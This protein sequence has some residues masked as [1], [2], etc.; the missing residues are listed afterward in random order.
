MRLTLFI[1]ALLLP[2]TLT[3]GAESTAAQPGIDGPWTVP[4]LVI[5]YFPVTADEKNIDIG[6][7]SN[8]SAPLETIRAK[9]D[10]MTRETAEALQE[11]SRFRAYNNRRAKPSLVYEIVGEREYLEPLPHDPRKKGYPDYRKILEREEIRAW[12]EE[13][14][15]RE[16]WIW[17]YHSKILAPWESNMA[18]RHGDVSNS[19]RDRDDLPILD[20][21]YIVYH[22][23]YERET[24]E[25]VHNHIHQI[26]AVMRHHGRELWQTFEGKRGAWRC[27]NCHFPPNAER[28]YDYANPRFVESDI[29]DWRPDGFGR[30]KR[31]N[32]RQ[33]DCDPL[34]WYV[35]WMRSIPGMHNGLTSRGQPLT[36][37]WIFMGDY[38]VGMEREVGLVE[39]ISKN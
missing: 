30:M 18:S 29:E 10:R 25:A 34:K 15:V 31:L 19:D 35:Y 33:W 28:D 4:V 9:C 14:G 17:G 12:V 36:N 22:Y 38:D 20:H 11:G 6:V 8:V 5:R 26:E 7:T 37:W 1:V 2:A 32:C 23:N 16:V 3:D 27:G 21:T 39:A 13:K 24:S